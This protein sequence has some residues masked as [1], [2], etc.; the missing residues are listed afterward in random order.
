MAAKQDAPEGENGAPAAVGRAILRVLNVLAELAARPA[1][2]TLAQLTVS[3][4]VPKASLFRI[5]QTLRQAGYLVQDE[6]TFR[7]GEHSFLLSRLIGEIAPRSSFPDC[8]RPVLNW[9]AAETGETAMLAQLA[10]DGAE[11]VYLAVAESARPIRFAVGEGDT[12]PLYCAAA[13]QAMLAFLPEERR[14]GYLANADFTPFTP[15]TCD[16]AQLARRLDE[17]RRT[18]VAID[19]GGRVEG[20]SGIACPVFDSAGQV[21]AAIAIAGPSDRIEAG[22]DPIAALARRGAE[23]VSRLLGHVS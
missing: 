22:R 4:D 2:M 12:R 10:K 20:A 14:R 17:I 23:R 16:A 9:L 6:G 11:I 5:L 3:L 1:G 8:A 7:L 18:G 21:W 15:L 13:G 19:R